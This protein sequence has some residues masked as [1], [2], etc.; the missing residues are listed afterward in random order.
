MESSV[1][2]TFSQGTLFMFLPDKADVPLTGP[3]EEGE[4]VKK[5]VSQVTVYCT[6][7]RWDGINQKYIVKCVETDPDD[8]GDSNDDHELINQRFKGPVK[9][10]RN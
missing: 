8:T 2:N 9:N 3:E 4:D 10:L 7:V 6:E 1:N 5:D